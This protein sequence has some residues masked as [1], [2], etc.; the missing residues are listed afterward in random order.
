MRVRSVRPFL[1]A[2]LV[3]AVLTPTVAAAQVAAPA[4]STR[5]VGEVYHIEL[6]G[7][8][9]GPSVFGTVSSE[10]FGIAGTD[11]KF[12]DD[13]GFEKTQ[14]ADVRLVLRPAKKHKFRV[15]YT[16]V[17]Y[18]AESTLD[19]EIVFNGILYPVNVP[20]HSTFDWKVWRFGYEYDIV[21]RDRGYFGVLIEARY[22]EM[23]A[24]L[25]SPVNDEFT[26]ARAPLPALGAVARFYPLKNLS[27]T[28]EISGLKIPEIDDKYEANYADIDIYGT[29]NVT[30]NFGAQAGWRRM[31]AFLRIETDKGDVRFQ[32]FWFGGAIRF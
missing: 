9:W 21:Y 10:Q 17:S 29:F 13:L 24:S 28:A 27:I 8:A 14:F 30:H 25:K 16:P 32:G 20:V 12:V 5:A 4:P 19:R 31:H 6:S 22:T 26:R 2:L 3:S 1:A 18:S 11:I 7:G 23:N 15:Q